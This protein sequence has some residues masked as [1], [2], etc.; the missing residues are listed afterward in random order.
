ML[1]FDIDKRFNNL[2]RDVDELG[3][4]IDPHSMV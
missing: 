2:I 1:D 4:Q 3:I